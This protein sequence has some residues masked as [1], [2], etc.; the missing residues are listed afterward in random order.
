MMTE[1]ELRA[2]ARRAADPPAGMAPADVIDQALR[3]AGIP[4]DYSTSAEYRRL[5]HRLA[6]STCDIFRARLQTLG[7]DVVRTQRRS[8]YVRCYPVPLAQLAHQVLREAGGPLRLMEVHRRLNQRGWR[9]S[10]DSVAGA[11]RRTPLIVRLSR[12]RYAARDDVADQTA[13]G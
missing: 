7:V 3:E 6:Q 1:S 11:L 8:R 4:G 5:W 2:I 10:M 9:V 12:G 13:A